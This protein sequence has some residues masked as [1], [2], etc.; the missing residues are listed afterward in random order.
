MTN[1]RA[2]VA[3]TREAIVWSSALRSRTARRVWFVAETKPLRNG[4]GSLVAIEGILTDITERGR[5]EQE[6]AGS[7]ALLAAA[8]ENSPDA[9]SRR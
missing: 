5:A 3:G 2:I 7:H 1:L 8:I 4:D 9:D 6:L